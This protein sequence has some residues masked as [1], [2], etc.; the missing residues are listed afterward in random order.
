MDRLDSMRVFLRVAETGS[1]TKAADLLDMPR[2]TVSAA[3]QQLEAQLGSRLLHRTT[4]QVQLTHDGSVV[5]ERCR[6]LLEDMEEL[7]SLFHDGSRASGRLKVDVPSRVARLLIAPALPEFFRQHPDIELELGSS[8]RSVDLVQEGVDCV[9]RVGQLGNS[10]LV[11]RRLGEMQLINCASPAYLEEHGEPRT[12]ADLDRHWAVNYASP[13]SGRVLPWEYRED[14]RT[15]TR[16]LR[17][18]VTVNNAESYIACCLSGLGLIQIP[19]YDVRE[20]LQRGELRE[21]LP[22]ESAERLASLGQVIQMIREFSD[23]Q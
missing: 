11:A 5:L 7:E 16:A 1:F 14:G 23:F 15:L 10:S 19:A 13:S 8:D 21:V 2:A 22:L 4:R 18:R 3:V 6:H 17:S 9:L 12:P 20:H